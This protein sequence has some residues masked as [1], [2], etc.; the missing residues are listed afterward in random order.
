MACLRDFSWWPIDWTND[1]QHASLPAE[2]IRE[3]G[4]LKNARLCEGLVLAVELNGVIYTAKITTR[5]STDFLI[6]LRHILLQHWG[7]PIT[8]VE[9][10]EIGFDY[11]L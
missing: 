2:E 6:L 5:L 3:R 1:A 4:V 10:V 11:L 8:N 9:D 7:E